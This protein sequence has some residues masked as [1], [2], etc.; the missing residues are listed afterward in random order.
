[1]VSRPLS[2]SVKQNPPGRNELKQIIE[3]AHISGK[4]AKTQLLRL[5]KQD[6]VLEHAK[7]VVSLIALQAA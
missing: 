3:I 1:M 5:K 4:N 7:A 6:A 2:R